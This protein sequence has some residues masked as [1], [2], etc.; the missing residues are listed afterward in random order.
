MPFT[1]RKISTLH[2]RKARDEVPEPKT[3]RLVHPN[4]TARPMTPLATPRSSERVR[5]LM[6]TSRRNS[7]YTRRGIAYDLSPL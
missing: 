7:P 1:D 5:T 4:D 6:T 3:H 2:P